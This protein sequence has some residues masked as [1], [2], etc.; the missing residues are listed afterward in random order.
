MRME[1]AHSRGMTHSHCLGLLR[2]APT[3]TQIEAAICEVRQSQPQP[4]LATPVDAPTGDG[5][6][7]PPP[8][9]TV[10]PEGGPRCKEIFEWV[11][12]NL[13]LSAWHPSHNKADWPPPEGQNAGPPAVNHL[14]LGVHE[15]SPEKVVEDITMLV[16]RVLM[17]VHSPYCR[18]TVRTASRPQV[19]CRMQHA[20]CSLMYANSDEGA[21]ATATPL[22][23][24]QTPMSSMG[25]R[26]SRVV[27]RR[28]L[29]VGNLMLY[30]GLGGRHAQHVGGGSSLTAVRNWFSKRRGTMGGWWLSFL[31]LWLASVPMWMPSL[32]WT[33]ERS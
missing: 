31:G 11:E 19:V 32:S 6:A 26:P 16:N 28:V 20:V 14:R 18:A 9:P 8:P 15:R 7:G 30:P 2:S 10:N 29:T 23:R 5:P 12:R 1:F 25:R 17:H 22:T 3:I 24:D 33:K 27:V 13:G 4:D 21:T